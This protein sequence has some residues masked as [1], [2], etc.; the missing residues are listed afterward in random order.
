MCKTITIFHSEFP[1]NESCTGPLTPRVKPC[2]VKGTLL[3]QV[4]AARPIGIPYKCPQHLQIAFY[5]VIQNYVDNI[6]MCLHGKPPNTC[7]K[8]E[9]LHDSVQPHVKQWAYNLF[10]EL[11]ADYHEAIRENIMICLDKKHGIERQP[12]TYADITREY[13]DRV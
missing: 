3:C 7:L 1:C 4:R 10:L 11:R 2:P 5:P 9:A 8:Y 13:L 12:K 6:T